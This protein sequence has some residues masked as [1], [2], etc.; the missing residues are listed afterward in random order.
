MDD[1]LVHQDGAPR[2]RL[3]GSRRRSRRRRRASRRPLGPPLAVEVDE[4]RDEERTPRAPVGVPPLRRRPRR[5]T[6]G[7]ASTCHVNSRR[8]PACWRRAA[9]HRC[10]RRR[11]APART[12][13]GRRAATAPQPPRRTAPRPLRSRAGCSPSR[14]AG[15]GR[16]RSCA[17][18]SARRAAPRRRRSPPAVASPQARGARCAARRRRGRRGVAVA[19]LANSATITAVA[20]GARRRVRRHRAKPSARARV[21]RQ[22]TRLAARRRQA[23]GWTATSAGCGLEG[24]RGAVA[25]AAPPKSR[26]TPP[27]RRGLLRRVAIFT[28][29]AWGLLLEFHSEDMSSDDSASWANSAGLATRASA[30]PGQR[31][32]AGHHHGCRGRQGL[33]GA[34]GVAQLLFPDPETTQRTLGLTGEGAAPRQRHGRA[35]AIPL[36]E[37]LASI[38]AEANEAAGAADAPARRGVRR[39]RADGVARGMLLALPEGALLAGADGVDAAGAS[40]A[41]SSRRIAPSTRSSSSS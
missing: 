12:G 13:V 3:H 34:A 9:S 39:R 23:S 6:A 37:R 33:A 22:S 19:A 20:A 32:A 7:S 28:L 16:R 24:V 41:A 30:P 31:P 40:S 4:E 35:P 1:V 36:A 21:A 11:R 2:P 14:A 8:A 10:R 38:A 5:C 25:P 27:R 17:P 26:T 18:R 15:R 29:V